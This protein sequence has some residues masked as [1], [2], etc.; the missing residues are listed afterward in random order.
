MSTRRPVDRYVEPEITDARVARQWAG[1]EQRMAKLRQAWWRLPALAA[2]VTAS[3]VLLAL[4]VHTRRGGGITEGALL[5]ST[6]PQTVTLNDGSRVDLAPDSRLHVNALEPKRIELDLEQGSA[7]FDVRHITGRRFVVQVGRFDIVDVGTRFDVGLSGAG[8]ITVSVEQGAVR[9]ERRDSSEPARFVSAGE[10]WSTSAEHAVTEPSSDA[11][12]TEP[13]LPAIPDA[14]EPSAH[15]AAAPAPA[16]HPTTSSPKDILE[17]AQRAQRAGRLRDAATDYDRLRRD[18]RSDGR[19]GL[20]AFEL[21]R[22][23]LGPL[24]DKHGA[25]EAFRDA[26]ALSPNAPFREDAE[27]HLVEALDGAGDA[28]RC[29]SARSTYLADYPHGLHVGSVSARCARTP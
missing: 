5:E 13:A 26:I 16:P 9:I 25:A 4:F 8:A 14:V 12:A 18:F 19:A 15:S 24:A 11:A 29:E 21:G 1:T 28:A 2:G 3:V 27:A 6:G 22:L 10:R 23:R 7:T 17:A 20:A